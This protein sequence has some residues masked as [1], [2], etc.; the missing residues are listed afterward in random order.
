MPLA[1]IG[2]LTPDLIIYT[3]PGDARSKPGKCVIPGLT[4]D[5]LRNAVVLE[6]EYKHPSL[7][8]MPC[9]RYIPGVRW[10]LWQAIAGYQLFTG[11]QPDCDAMA[12]TI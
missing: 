5:L 4:G 11:E 10:L 2:L 1:D 3:V 7:V 6:A 12:R 9:K 8:S